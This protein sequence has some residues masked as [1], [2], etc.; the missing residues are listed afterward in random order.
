MRRA[1]VIELT[2]AE[3]AVFVKWS[4]RRT[5]AARLVV[6]ANIF[7]QAAAGMYSQGIAAQLEIPPKTVCKWR[8]RFTQQRLL[9]I[10][11]DA[12]RG[13]RKPSVRNQL[14]AEIIRKT[15]QD[16]PAKR[17]DW[18][19]RKMAQAAGISQATV[20]RVWRD[21]ELG[22]RGAFLGINTNGREPVLP[23]D[24]NES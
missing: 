7:L 16:K 5:V 22:R 10:E 18:A 2:D 23:A 1:A 20:N 21:K 15:T 12:S 3:P 6:R 4:K 24:Y 14:E 11:W 9:G 17:L 8:C 13:G 19:T